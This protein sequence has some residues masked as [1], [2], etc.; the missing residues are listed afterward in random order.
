MSNELFL[1]TSAYLILTE[2]CNLRCT[3]CF[4]RNSRA[5]T[6]YMPEETA[7]KVVDKLFENVEK[8]IEA[9]NIKRESMHVG[10]TFF[11][12]E[13]CLCPEM[14]ARV[15]RYG[16]NLSKEK[17]IRITFSIIT[18][19][20]IYNEKLEAFMEEWIELTNGNI[21]IQLSID[22][23]PDI[24]DANRPCAISTQKSSELIEANV[25]KFKKFYADHNIDLQKLQ[26]HAV[27]SKSSLPTL[28]ES[29]RYFYE[30][31]KIYESKFAWVIEDKW[32]DDDIAI[33]DRELGNIVNYL[34][35]IT[36][37]IDRFPLKHFDRCSGCSAG[38]QL[39]CVDTEGNIYPCHRFF[40]FARENKDLIFGN[41]NDSELDLENAESRKKFV[42]FD[43]SEI[44]DVCQICIATNYE[45]T[46]TLD[47]RPSDY[48]VK[49]MEVING[50]FDIYQKAIN[51]KL[52]VQTINHLKNKIDYLEAVISYNNLEKPT[53]EFIRNRRKN[54]NC[55]G[56]C[57]GD[58]ECNCKKESTENK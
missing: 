8:L 23:T 21:S 30:T 14:M 28:F 58:G 7:Y 16:V 36:T 34:I 39:V 57:K 40:F 18:N 32:D 43:T 53:E 48:D 9:N 31:L 49:F 25:V 44:K 42:E 50:W 4:E 1:P 54:C 29:F 15:L 55:G 22:G 46:G 11:G 56:N 52:I 19:G 27:I 17:D 10:I 47:G 45:A 20:T 51:D 33:L 5:V 38:K 13:P 24:Q 37:N 41:I 6:Q 3:Y 26:L 2:N 35:P 12:G